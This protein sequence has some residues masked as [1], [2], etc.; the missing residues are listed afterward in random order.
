M[1]AQCPDAPDCAV[2]LA[3]ALRLTAAAAGCPVRVA[4]NDGRDWSSATFTGMQ[5]RITLIGEDTPRFDQWLSTLPEIDIP[6]T[7]HIVSDLTIEHFGIV[8]GERH[9]LIFALTVAAA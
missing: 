3:R 6:L 8:D 2:L 4:A 5:H 1:T 7:G 9:A